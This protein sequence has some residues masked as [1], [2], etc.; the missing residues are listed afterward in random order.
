MI[1]SA[2][3]P[4]TSQAVPSTQ[5]TLLFLSTLVGQFFITLCN[6]FLEG[7]IICFDLDF[8]VAI[9]IPPFN[10]FTSN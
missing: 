10:G 1:F 8:L 9:L 3:L 2:A 4:P 6:P 5:L 7:R